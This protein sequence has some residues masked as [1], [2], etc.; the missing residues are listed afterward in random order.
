MAV[1]TD[2]GHAH[3]IDLFEEGP[4]ASHRPWK[5]EARPQP[6]PKPMNCGENM[7]PTRWGAMTAPNHASH[8]DNHKR[9][10]DNA[11]RTIAF[12]DFRAALDVLSIPFRSG[13]HDTELRRVNGST[14]P[15]NWTETISLTVKTRI[16][17]THGRRVTEEYCCQGVGT[18][19]GDHRH[20][21]LLNR[22]T[23][24]IEPP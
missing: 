18:M 23:S 12:S 3:S 4:D 9:A 20:D 6:R 21:P 24:L 11:D 10:Y 8:T 14:H 15:R 7:I 17:D 13:P 22:R 19:A 16:K 2:G 1:S 5:R